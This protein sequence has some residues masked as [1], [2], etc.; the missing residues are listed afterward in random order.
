MV[1]EDLR[2]TEARSNGVASRSDGW[3][4]MFRNWNEVIAGGQ[5]TGFTVITSKTE[6][7]TTSAYRDSRRR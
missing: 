4:R 7:R 2:G 6:A 3:E 5:A 1:R